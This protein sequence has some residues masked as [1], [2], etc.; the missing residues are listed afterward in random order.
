MA[1]QLHLAQG[2]CTGRIDRCESTAPESDIEALRRSVVPDVVR[3]V[4]KTN[5][6]A[7]LIRVRIQQLKAFTCAVRDRDYPSLRDDGDALRLSKTLQ[8]LQVRAVFD[9]QHLN[10]V[11]PQRR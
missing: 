11:V 4:A 5:R 2:L 1:G 9:V 7:E 10:G 8:A 6:R 3:V